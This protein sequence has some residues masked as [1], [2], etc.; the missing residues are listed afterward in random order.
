MRQQVTLCALG[1][2]IGVGVI[3]KVNAH[4]YMDFPKAR[5]A[6]CQ[7]QGGFWWPKDGS[8]IPNAACRAAYVKSEHVQFIQKHEFATNTADFHNQ[9][10]VEANIPDGTLCGAGDNQKAGM[11]IPSKDWQKTEITPN[12][13]GKVKIRYR[14]T[15][16]HNP[17][18][19]QFYL[20][21]PG[22]EF[23][24]NSL[25][26][27]DLELVQE[28]G[29]IPFFMAPDGKRYYEME[30]AIPDKFSG[31]AILYSRWQRDDVVGEGFYNCSDVTIVRNTDPTPTPETWYPV[32]YF[33]KQGQDA[34]AGDT[35]WVRV[36]N[37]NGNEI[38]Q[39]KLDITDANVSRWQFLFASRLNEQYTETVR[40]GVKD[41]QGNI[42]FDPNA[43]S[44]NQVF[45]SERANSYNLTVISKPKNTAPTVH[46]PAPITMDEG[47]SKHLH[48]HAFDDEQSELEFDWHLP[49]A[50]TFSGTGST[51]TIT[52]PQV[53]ADARFDGKV[54][55]SD[56]SL[57]KTVPLIINV[58][59]IE[60]D[61][62][63]PDKPS[64]DTWEPSKVYT[65]GDI[66]VYQ[67][68]SYRAKWWVRGQTPTSSNAWEL[69]QNGDDTDASAWQANKAY[70][71]GDIVTFNGT[72][73]QA[74]WWTRNQQPDQHSVWK[75]L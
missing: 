74:R 33:V 29:N 37:G 10:A 47:Q 41:T 22:V 48:V 42:V 35:V 60:T 40:I 49:N 72:Q 26:W 16:P 15:T 61:P 66:V 17:S 63:T 38:I 13:D 24:Q 54:T 34:K 58:K 19:W 73:Y 12:A 5:Q 45:L 75:K 27:R 1:V 67:G 2:A 50:L 65:A 55:V 6:I 25:A 14:A 7:E 20:T 46:T 43:I 36:F 44:S 51:I 68:K 39:E 4:G 21:K 56:G 8:K 9:A 3:G 31:D 59:N 18:F 52:A 28:H 30:I 11:N 23:K 69:V 70:R 53:D 62:G 32:G 64:D 57:S 71:G